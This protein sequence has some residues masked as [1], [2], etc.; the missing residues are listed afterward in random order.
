MSQTCPRCRSALPQEDA[1]GRRICPHCGAA[2]VDRD[3]V[4]LLFPRRVA[5]VDGAEHYGAGDLT[6]TIPGVTIED[7]LGQ[8]GLGLTYRATRDGQALVVKA[9]YP[10]L[11]RAED[12][13][14]RLWKTAAAWLPLDIPGVAR[15]LGTHVCPDPE[16]PIHCLLAEHVAGPDFR[17]FLA[18][19]PGRTAIR[20]AL[21]RLAET[22]YAV[23]QAGRM[24]LNVKAENVRLRDGVPVLLDLG[25][26]Q[27][28]VG[29]EG[30]PAGLLVRSHVDL[31]TQAYMPPDL[32]DK[33]RPASPA[34]DQ[35]SLGVLA[36]EAFTGSIPYDGPWRIRE[37]DVPA[38]L[39]DAIIRL[40]NPDPEGR[41][42]DMEEAAVA[43]GGKR[44][45][46][47]RLFE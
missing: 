15:C 9:V 25:Q 4:P 32:R 39:A 46:W 27:I 7:S 44:G 8:G 40:L 10:S 29:P 16:T 37:A 43:L 42:A 47:Q 5:E 28:V 18:T 6:P 34:A 22:L 20:R 11:C 1:P 35:Y 36:F 19:R 31:G 24:H 12:F 21:A 17:G 33:R 14:E 13:A 26:A 30:D 41:F 38:P 45:W 3:G 23:H 2:F